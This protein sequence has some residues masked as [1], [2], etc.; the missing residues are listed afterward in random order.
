MDELTAHEELPD[1]V[2]EAAMRFCSDCFRIANAGSGDPANLIALLD[3]YSYE[4]GPPEGDD[5]ADVVTVWGHAF[6][7]TGAFEWG[8]SSDG[9]H[10][11]R[12][13]FP[14]YSM[15]SFWPWARIR[16]ITGGDRSLVPG[17]WITDLTE[18]LQRNGS[19]P[20]R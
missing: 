18:D 20:A 4:H 11:L 15:F 5:L 2:H 19:R 13:S 10:L 17:E 7:A 3:Q 16:E 9:L 6:V 1:A 12:C 8:I 14:A